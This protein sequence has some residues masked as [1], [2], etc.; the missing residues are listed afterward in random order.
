MAAAAAAA[1]PCEPA[2]VQAMYFLDS[3]TSPL[4]AH[5][6]RTPPGRRPAATFRSPGTSIKRPQAPA[7]HLSRAKH[8]KIEVPLNQSFQK[9]I[10]ALTDQV[11]YDEEYTKEIRRILDRLVINYKDLKS[12][13]VRGNKWHAEST[14]AFWPSRVA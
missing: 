12:E 2:T 4:H 1:G 6:Y 9:A 10:E 7:K 14:S 3:E 13:E 11:R 5:R 8:Q